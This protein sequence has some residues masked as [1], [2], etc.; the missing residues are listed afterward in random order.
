MA[1][2]TENSDHTENKAYQTFFNL[3]GELPTVRFNP[4]WAENS[5]EFHGM[6]NGESA[7]TMAQCESLGALCRDNAACLSFIDSHRRCGVYLKNGNYAAVIYEHYTNGELLDLC[8]SLSD[9]M[10]TA[11]EEYWKNKNK[12]VYSPPTLEQPLSVD[13][14]FQILGFFPICVN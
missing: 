6:V 11:L 13:F 1:D 10:N 14:F 9:S 8:A 12:G 3:F 2:C 5:L 7:L 4:A